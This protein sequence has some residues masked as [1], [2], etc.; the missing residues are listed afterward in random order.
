MAADVGLKSTAAVA[1]FAA[2]SF[3]LTLSRPTRFVFGAPRITISFC[4]RD[5]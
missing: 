5:K 1:T 2:V 3:R 4:Q